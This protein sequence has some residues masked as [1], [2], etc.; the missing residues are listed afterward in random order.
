MLSL[1]PKALAAGMSTIAIQEARIPY[2]MAVAPDSF[3]RNLKKLI[4]IT[5]P[6]HFAALNH[7]R[8]EHIAKV[9]VRDCRFVKIKSDLANYVQQSKTLPSMVDNSVNS[10]F[11]HFSDLF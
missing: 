8:S 7:L 3:L 6:T 4:F 1:E 5:N 9:Q 2:S 11:F 10:P